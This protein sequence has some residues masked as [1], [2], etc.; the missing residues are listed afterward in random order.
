MADIRLSGGDS[1]SPGAACKNE[2]GDRQT[3]DSW[4]DRVNSCMVSQPARQP[5]SQREGGREGGSD[6]KGL[7]QPW[8]REA[9]AALM[10]G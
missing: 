9:T 10:S 3:A 7:W 1:G 5:G 6:L 8:R 2:A 4:T